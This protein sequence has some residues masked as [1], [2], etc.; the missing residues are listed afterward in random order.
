MKDFLK[1]NTV[2]LLIV[3]ATIVLAGIAVST[4]IRLYQLRQTS[5]AP[6]APTSKP[7]AAAAPS[8]ACQLA[9]TIATA[10]PSP[11]PV[12]QCNSTCTTDTNCPSTMTCYHNCIPGRGVACSIQGV[13]RNTVCTT[14]STCTCATSTPTLTPTPTATATTIA[15]I[16]P[17]PTT[18]PQCN[19]SCST[20]SDCPS[21]M[22]C[23]GNVCRNISCTSSTT[24]VCSTATPTATA[25]TIAYIPTTPTPSTIVTVP[26]A[27]PTLPKSGTVE[28][29]ILGIGV[30]AILLIA[31]IA[32]IL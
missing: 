24:C 4:A 19:S 32:L 29:T 28:P 23:A 5:V 15:S 2:T 22:T 3:L 10:S 20:A 8:S 30:G 1:K 26:T 16:T 14:D 12:P 7:K 13:C 9:F 18:P 27:T 31:G 17:T 25:T 11:T 21:G 6:N